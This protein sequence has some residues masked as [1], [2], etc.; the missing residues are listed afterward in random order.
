MGRGKAKESHTM[1]LYLSTVKELDREKFLNFYKIQG[2]SII[3][4]KLIQTRYKLK[5]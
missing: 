2:N 1:I 4:L 3:K 5:K